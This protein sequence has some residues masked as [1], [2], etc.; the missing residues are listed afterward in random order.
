M[1]K[2]EILEHWSKLEANQKLNVAPTPYKHQGS[3][4]MMDSIRIT[5]SQEFIDSVLSRIKDVLQYENC[6]N[7]LGLSYQQSKD[8]DTGIEL[9]D[10]WNCYIQV[11]QRGH[12][13]RMINNTFGV[14]V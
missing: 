2:A 11:H 10:A 12:E 4:Y 14:I 5:G 13:A 8:K 3:T 1:N 6:D 7:R 9:T